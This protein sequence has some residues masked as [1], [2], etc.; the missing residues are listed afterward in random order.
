MAPKCCEKCTHIDKDTCAHFRTCPSWRKWF[1]RQWE[2]I[3][4]RAA[5]VRE[6]ERAK[7]AGTGSLN[8]YSSEPCA[9]MTERR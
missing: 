1:S 7:A 9:P 3:R 2:G 4:I 5:E 8:S 6:H